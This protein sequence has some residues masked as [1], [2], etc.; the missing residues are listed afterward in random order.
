MH[1]ESSTGWRVKTQN[2]LK[3]LET[4]LL[5]TLHCT[6]QREDGA[7]CKRVETHA[8]TQATMNH[9]RDDS[10]REKGLIS[11]FDLSGLMNAF[12]T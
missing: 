5:S 2:K 6:I 3:P 1:R 9:R 10:K 11:V 8:H 12:I 4:P 7:R